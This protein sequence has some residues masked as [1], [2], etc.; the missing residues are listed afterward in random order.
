MRNCRKALRWDFVL[1]QSAVRLVPIAYFY[2]VEGNVLFSTTD[3]RGLSVLAGWIWLQ[4][5]V[6]ACQEVLGPRFFVREGWAPPAYDYHPMLREDEE[7]ATMPIG[8]SSSNPSP[9]ADD[10][11]THLQPGE[12]KGK[13][14][15]VFDCSICAADIEVPV[16]PAGG[17]GVEGRGWRVDAAE[18]GVHGY[19][20]SAYFSHGCL[21]DGCGNAARTGTNTKSG[22]SAATQYVSSAPSSIFPFDFDFQN[23]K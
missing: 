8:S 20:L 12:S 23:I 18:E 2:A 1:G 17:G 4:I 22:I 15:K 16:I 9:T 5:C 11:E 6:L 7:G 10:E 14:R 13:G 3:L 19:A 21:E